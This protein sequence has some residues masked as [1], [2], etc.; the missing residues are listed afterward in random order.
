MLFMSKS[1]KKEKK[2]NNFKNISNKLVFV[3]L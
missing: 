2:K 1:K 3:I